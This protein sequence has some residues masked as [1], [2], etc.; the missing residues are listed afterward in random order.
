MATY[1]NALSREPFTEGGYTFLKRV[2]REY[3][4]KG[5]PVILKVGGLYL[6]YTYRTGQQTFLEGMTVLEGHD[7]DALGR[8]REVAE[9][10]RVEQGFQ[11]IRD[12]R[13]AERGSEVG[14]MR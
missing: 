7:E 3:L 13:R 10:Y 12:E 1:A 9:K 14:R 5:G 2:L 4:E 8:F 6:S 11:E